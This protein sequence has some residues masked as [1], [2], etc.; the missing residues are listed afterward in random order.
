MADT[1]IPDYP[2][3]LT[4]EKEVKQAALEAGLYVLEQSGD[5]MKMDIPGGFIPKEW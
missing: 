4:F 5:T 1:A 3:G 2:R